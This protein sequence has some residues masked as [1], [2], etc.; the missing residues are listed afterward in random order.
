MNRLLVAAV[1]LAAPCAFADPPSS[2]LQAASIVT[3][4]GTLVGFT[5]YTTEELY[6]LN[7]R[8][9]EERKSS[10]FV[11][12]PPTL[13][14]IR[15][16]IKHIYAVRFFANIFK[17]K[18]P[19]EMIVTTEPIRTFKQG[20][21]LDVKVSSNP[22][23]G[24]KWYGEVNRVT[25]EAVKQLQSPPLYSCKTQYD[26]PGTLYY[27]VSYNPAVGETELGPL[28]KGPFAP[29]AEYEAKSTAALKYQKVYRLAE[30]SD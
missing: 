12:E 8:K 9:T 16:F 27:W 19:V 21:Y 28:C 20:E 7:V 18:H 25:P 14:E 15:G 30:S 1:F 6:Q 24:F 10:E 4:S 11:E 2:V 26:G 22:L 13:E 23:N 29:R 3:A 5:E 17:V